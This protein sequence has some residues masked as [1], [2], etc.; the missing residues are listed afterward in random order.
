MRA[1]DLIN[2]R[3]T[4]VK[5]DVCCSANLQENKKATPPGKIQKTAILENLGTEAVDTSTTFVCCHLSS[6]AVAPSGTCCLDRIVAN[7]KSFPAL[8]HNH[9]TTND[10]LCV[11]YLDFPREGGQEPCFTLVSIWKHL[12]SGGVWDTGGVLPDR[13]KDDVGKMA[14]PRH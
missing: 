11:K 9:V 2:S 14:A 3:N 13:F 5:L 8:P 6:G 12:E 10:L 4:N 1:V 7:D